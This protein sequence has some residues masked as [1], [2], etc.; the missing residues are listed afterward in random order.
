MSRQMIAA[1]YEM[2]ALVTPHHRKTRL[3][4]LVKIFTSQPSAGRGTAT[5]RTP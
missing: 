2:R 1:R 4:W 5:V 3:D